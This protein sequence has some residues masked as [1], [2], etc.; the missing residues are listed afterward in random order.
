MMT[1]LGRWPRIS[2]SGPSRRFEQP[3]EFDIDRA[4]A[5]QHL[6]FG[7]GAHTCPGAPLARAE[8]CASVERLLAR[9]ADIRISESEHGPAD[10][11]RYDYAPTYILR[12]LQRLHLEF[13]PAG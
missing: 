12:G 11:R 1:T 2:A 4:T 13:A 8:A 7:H 6:A 9:M 3:D 10:A 5:R